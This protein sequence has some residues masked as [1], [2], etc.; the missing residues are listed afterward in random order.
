MKNRRISYLAGFAVV[1][2]LLFLIAGPAPAQDEQERGTNWGE[3]VKK[4]D[5]KYD[6]ETPVPA[7]L[8]AASKACNRCVHCKSNCPLER[9]D[10]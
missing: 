10:T 4:Y 5:I 1:A 6:P 9:H 8:S 2:F 7:D 3:I